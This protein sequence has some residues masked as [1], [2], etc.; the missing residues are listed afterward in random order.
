M[1]KEKPLE[2]NPLMIIIKRE[3]KFNRKNIKEI[4]KEIEIEIKKEIEK[5]RKSI[6][7]IK[8]IKNILNESSKN[9]IALLLK[10]SLI[11]CIKK[12]PEESLYKI[13]GMSYIQYS[14]YLI[15]M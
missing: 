4:E 10:C 1:S 2:I 8:N 12:F 15:Y 7:N 11:F 6:K 13:S 14:N 5:N 3:I 9:N